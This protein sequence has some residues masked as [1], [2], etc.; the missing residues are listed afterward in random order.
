MV[1]LERAKKSNVY[2]VPF[3]YK[4]CSFHFWLGKAV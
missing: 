2:S 1:L 3:D 4:Y